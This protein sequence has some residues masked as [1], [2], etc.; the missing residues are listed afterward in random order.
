MRKSQLLIIVSLFGL[1]LAL[2]LLSGERAGA[3]G[4]FGG[5]PWY[6]WAG[7]LL[8]LA[9]SGVVLLLRDAQRARR[10]LEAPPAPPPAVEDPERIVLTPAQLARYDRGGPDYPHPVIIAENCIGCHLCVEACPHDVLSVID[11]LA[12]VTAR[13]LCMEDTSC[14]VECPVSPKACVVVNATKPIPKRKVPERDSRFETNVRGC[15]LVGDVSGT[16]LIKNAANEGAAV[17]G[18]VLDDLSRAPREPKSDLDVLIV[19]AGPAGL[20]AA[21]VAAQAGLR[22]ACVE[23]DKLLATIEAFPANKFV[24][25]KPAQM[26]A[27]AGL[28]VGGAGEPR[29]QVLRRWRRTADERGVRV[30]EFETCKSV[31]RAPDGDYFV[32]ST[33][34]GVAREGREYR[35]RRVVLA[36]GNRGMAK[37][38]GVPGEDL[39]VVR[40]GRAEDKVKYR[41]A[42]A[43]AYRG[44]RI[45]V[46]GAG[47]S[48]VEAAVSLVAR[49][50]GERIEFRP[51]GERNEVT[52]LVRGGMRNDLK[53]ANKQQVY[54]CID[55]GLIDARFGV[56]VRE[57]RDGEILLEDALTREELGALPNDFVFA[58]IGGD[59]P[60]EFLKSIGINIE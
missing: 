38:L 34:R 58:L 57:V 1:L 45:V 60:T 8:F 48:A 59:R 54:H 16:P 28:A 22:Y 31:G 41:L 37:R 25:F 19:G 53:F 56:A 9:A 2:N 51:A 14:Q 47:N 12:T 42:D 36:L 26:R 15:Y 21:V 3:K 5:L 7:V 27:R 44:K 10:L 52:L 23:Q 17:V 40:D 29:E 4:F 46:V 35:P 55:E 32:V 30:S 39:K 18:H 20:S 11:G 6:G 43:E 13:D 33:E 24:H 50:A 49:R